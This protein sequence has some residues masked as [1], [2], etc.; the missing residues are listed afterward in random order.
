MLPVCSTCHDLCGACLCITQ[1]IR[2]VDVLILKYLCSVLKIDRHS[3]EQA[4][5][6]RKASVQERN[7]MVEGVSRN[8]PQPLKLVNPVIKASPRSQSLQ[9][10]HPIPRL[11]TVRVEYGDTLADIAY[12][13]G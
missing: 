13:Y 6:G 9:N 12:E 8:S 11:Q 1:I 4:V 3:A 10:S 7:A 2:C 5:L